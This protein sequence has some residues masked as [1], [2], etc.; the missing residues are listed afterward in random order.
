M[1][2]KSWNQIRI[3][4]GDADPDP[5]PE[6]RSKETAKLTNKPELCLSE[7]LLILRRYGM[8][9]GLLPTQSTV[10]IFLI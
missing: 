8:F 1:E 7:R 6:S 2:V 3:C 9:F 4:I 5:D 10:P